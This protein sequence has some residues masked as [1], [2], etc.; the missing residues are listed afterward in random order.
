MQLSLCN[1]YFNEEDAVLVLDFQ[2]RFV[3][4]V[5]ILGTNEEEACFALLY[6]LR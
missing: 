3:G 6:V 1:N 5:D 4:E 2:Y